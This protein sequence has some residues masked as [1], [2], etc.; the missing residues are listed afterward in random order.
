MHTR[1]VK[2]LENQG[3][4]VS[5]HAAPYTWIARKGNSV[6][7]W[8]SFFGDVTNEVNTTID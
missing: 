5:Q 4:Q 3:Y 2:R 1:K 8:V 7:V 6:I